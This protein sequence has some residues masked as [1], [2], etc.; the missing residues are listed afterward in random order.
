MDRQSTL[1]G[2]TTS[3]RQLRMARPDLELAW[4][5]PAWSEAGVTLMFQHLTREPRFEV[6]QQML[7]LTSPHTDRKDAA[8][9]MAEQLAS[10]SPDDWIRAFGWQPA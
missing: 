3:V 1:P 5:S 8:A 4:T 2:S 6:R 7:R 10:T 9:D